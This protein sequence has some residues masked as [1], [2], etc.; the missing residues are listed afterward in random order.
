M[1]SL[2]VLESKV[3][4]IEKRLSELKDHPTKADIDK[5]VEVVIHKLDDR[6]KIF[7]LEMSNM[8]KASQIAYQETLYRASLT[9]ENKLDLRIKESVQRHKDKMNWGMEVVRIVIVGT[10]FVLSLKLIN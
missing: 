6:D 8:Q 10:M 2:E 4:K 7:S 5:A 9:L 3:H 1:P